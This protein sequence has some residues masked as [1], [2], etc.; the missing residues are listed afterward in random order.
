ML[1]GNATFLKKEFIQ[2]GNR[3]NVEFRKVQDLQTI[4]EIFIVRPQRDPQ[5]EVPKDKVHPLYTPLRRSDKVRQVSLRYG[6][7]IGNDKEINIIEDNDLLTYSEAVMS[8]DFGRWLE[9]TKSEMDSMY[10]NQVWTLVD[11]SEGVTPIGCKW[12]F[13]KKIRADGQVEPYQG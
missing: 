10:T 3:R 5:P 7:V 9:A 1:V 2:R 8:R 11:A 6:F 13:K 4:S 12:I